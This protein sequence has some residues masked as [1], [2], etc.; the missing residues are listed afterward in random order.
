MKIIIHVSKTYVSENYDH[1]KKVWHDNL[2]KRVNTE[3]CDPD[4]T[5]ADTIDSLSHIA[6]VKCI[7]PNPLA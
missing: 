5:L 4:K 1:N 3:N 7:G 2:V 6:G